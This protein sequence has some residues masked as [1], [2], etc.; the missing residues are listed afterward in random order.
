MAESEKK[1]KVDGKASTLPIAMV[2]VADLVP[3]HRNARL[4]G[5]RNKAA[6]LASIR[7][8]G[9]RAPLV[10]QRETKRVLAG[11]LRLECLR[12]LGYAAAPVLWVD[13]DDPTAAAFAIADNRTAELAEWDTMTLAS[14]LDELREVDPELVIGWD[15]TVGSKAKGSSDDAPPDD[16]KEFGEDIATEYECPKCHYAWSGKPK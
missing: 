7:R 11:N 16:F 3:D 10:V 6:V 1:T 9:V 15:D 5:D 13:D 8:F 2:P 12:E 4:H 14:I